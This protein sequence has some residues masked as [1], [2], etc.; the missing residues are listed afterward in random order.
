MPNPNPMGGGLAGLCSFRWMAARRSRRIARQRSPVVTWATK[1]SHVYLEGALARALRIAQQAPIV[2]EL[3]AAEYEALEEAERLETTST[4]E[5]MN[6]HTDEEAA[7]AARDDAREIRR[8]R[9]AT[10]QAM[11]AMEE[12]AATVEAAAHERAAERSREIAA[13][14]RSRRKRND[15]D[16]R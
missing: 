13:D 9:I 7:A 8:E 4:L 5:R 2:A 15:T 16:P 10:E 3:T 1:V 6:A 11:A 12:Q 14:A